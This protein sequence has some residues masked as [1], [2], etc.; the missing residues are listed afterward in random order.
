MTLKQRIQR[1]LRQKQTWVNGAQIEELAQ[2]K[3]YKASN[4]SRRL[5]ELA[6]EGVIER[7]ERKGKRA[8]T[9][10]YRYKAP[11]YYTSDAEADRAFHAF[12]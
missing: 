8:R 4:A 12:P 7:Q 3:G 11:V 10:W 2:K 5:R 9:V 6:Q 1:Y